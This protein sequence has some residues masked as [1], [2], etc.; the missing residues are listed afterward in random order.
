[1]IEHARG[2]GRP[3]RVTPEAIEAVA[4]SA[5]PTPAQRPRNSRLNTRKLQDSFGLC[6]P[7]WQAGVDR[8]LAEIL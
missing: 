8:L 3:I 6:L 1:M 4:T 2:A 5:F 7:A